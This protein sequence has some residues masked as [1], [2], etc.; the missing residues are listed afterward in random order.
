M[1]PLP[2]TPSQA[3][4]RR[5]D[6]LSVGADQLLQLAAFEHLHHDV[7]SA[8]ELALHVEL[9]NRRPVG[10][11]LDCLADLRVLEHVHRFVARAEPLENGD[12]AARKAALREQRRPLHEQDDV[13]V[14]HDL[15]DPA[16]GVTHWSSPLAPPFRAA[17]REALPQHAP[18][19]LN[20]RP[21]A[22]EPGLALRSFGSLRARH[23]DR[24]PRQGRGSSPPRREWIPGSAARSRSRASASEAKSVHRFVASMIWRR[25]SISLLRSASRTL[26]S[27]MSTP[28]EVRSPST[29]RITSCS[30]ASSK[31]ERT[32]SFA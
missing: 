24:R 3:R 16:A 19:A 17:V 31:S 12:C 32:T 9:R 11:F 14:L 5:E 21:G 20:K 28:A 2:T 7:G 8:D 29:F 4:G 18:R 10:I 30:P 13:V 1:V 25:A 26:S 6:E 15:V 22:G 23:N 27:S